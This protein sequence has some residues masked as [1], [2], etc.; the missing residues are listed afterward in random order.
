MNRH[1]GATALVALDLWLLL[2]AIGGISVLLAHT[3]QAGEFYLDAGGGLTQFRR[4]I[5]DGTWIQDGLPHNTQ[6][7]TFGW[8]TGAGYRISP[9]WSVQA[10]Y[11]NLGTVAIDA[12][13]TASEADYDRVAHRCTQNC[14]PTF[15]FHTHDLMEGG[16]LSV[17]RH[18]SIGPV[19]PFVRVGGAA[20]YHRL[21]ASF[22]GTTLTMHGWIPTALVGGGLCYGWVCADTTYYRG[23]GGPTDW[24]QGLPIAK[25]AFVS[26][27]NLTVPLRW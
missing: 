9:E 4:T 24:S 6:T 5:E 7:R 17:S 14:S 19:A 11:I 21:T 27:I 26:L 15:G 22:G 8:R 3:S 13:T 20:L 10:H 16:E 2:V 23:M 18:F 1:H 12:Q 25:Q